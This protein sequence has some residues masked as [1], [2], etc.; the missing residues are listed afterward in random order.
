MKVSL[1]MKEFC[2]QLTKQ[3]SVKSHILC[4]TIGGSFDNDT[5]VM[6]PDLADCYTDKDCKPIGQ[7]CNVQVS[8]CVPNN[9]T[10]KVDADCKEIGN[11]DDGSILGECNN[12]TCSYMAPALI[13]S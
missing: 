1:V 5:V 12:N 4:R 8:K 7:V 9:G 11:D 3:L 2:I 6:A 10:C 13:V